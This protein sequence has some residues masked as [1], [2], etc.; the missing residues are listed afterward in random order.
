MQ[1][2]LKPNVDLRNGNWRGNIL[3]SAAW[4][5]SY[6]DFMNDWAD[7]AEQHQVE[8]LSVGT[9]Y[10]RLQGRESDWR[11]VIASVRTAIRAS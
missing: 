2:L 7:F 9:E 3:P 10:N 11:N 1:V 5:A 6:T 4:F 8:M